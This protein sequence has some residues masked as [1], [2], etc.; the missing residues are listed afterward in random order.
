MTLSIFSCAYWPTVCLLWR[1][2]YLGLLL[3]FH[4][5]C[6]LLLLRC[7]SCV[8]ILE[9]MCFSVMSFANSFS[10]SIDCLFCFFFF[11]WFSLLYKGFPWWLSG[12]ESACNVGDLGSIPGLERSP[13]EGHGNPLR[14]SY[15][16]NSMDREAWQATVHGVTKNQERLSDWHFHLLY[17]NL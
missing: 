6:F 16:E 11:L 13:G 1:N 14:Y 8:H 3:I 4:L 5:G 17:K 7:M 9:N 2:V 15:L 12:K 10:H